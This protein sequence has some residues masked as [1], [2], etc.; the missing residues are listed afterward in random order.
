MTPQDR[1]E[2]DPQL[3]IVES[4]ALDVIG[5]LSRE[6]RE[7]AECAVL[8]VFADLPGDW[9]E[10]VRRRMGWNGVVDHAIAERW[11][12]ARREARA[13]GTEPEPAEF[14]RRFADEAVQRA[15]N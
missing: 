15:R 1:Y 5:E 4:Y 12:H 3:A 10:R 7:E 2:A 11:R 9:R 8:A 6:E 13:A 14:A